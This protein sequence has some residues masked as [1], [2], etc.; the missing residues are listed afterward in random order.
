MVGFVS[1]TVLFLNIRF[2]NYV[3]FSTEIAIAHF[4]SYPA[5]L[6]ASVWIGLNK[7]LRTVFM[8]LVIPSHVPLHRL[9]GATGLQ[10]LFAGMFYFTVGPVIGRT[11]DFFFIH[12]ILNRYKTIT[13]WIRDAT[14][15]TVTLHCLNIATF[16]TAICWGLEKVITDRRNRKRAAEEAEALET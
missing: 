7:G 14:N 6:A 1:A 3:N 9:P 12:Y 15:Y 11:Y 13:G 8:A 2:V 16:T 10:L 4:H 5:V